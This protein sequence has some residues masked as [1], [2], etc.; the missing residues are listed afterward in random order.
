MAYQR[1]HEKGLEILGVSLDTQA[2]AWQA[3]IR[4]D[5]LNWL[6][7]CDFNGWDGKVPAMY[8]VQSI[9]ANYLIDSKGNILAKNLKPSLMIVGFIGDDLRRAELKRWVSPNPV[10]AIP[11]TLVLLRRTEATWAIQAVRR[12][13]GIDRLDPDDDLDEGPVEPLL[14]HEQEALFTLG[15]CFEATIAMLPECTPDLLRRA[16]RSPHAPVLDA[17]ASRGAR[18]KTK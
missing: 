14:P 17:V 7:V 10:E 16:S 4:K 13:R 5:A 12:V 18:W 1:Y 11:S 9:P 3:A 2:E 8:G 6:Q 15:P